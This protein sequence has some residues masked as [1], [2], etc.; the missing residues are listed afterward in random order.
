[1]EIGVLK[2]ANK[3]LSNFADALETHSKY[4]TPEKGEGN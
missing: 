1:M 2:T 4:T 3:Q